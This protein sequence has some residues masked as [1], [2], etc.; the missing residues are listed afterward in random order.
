MNVTVASW[1]VDNIYHRALFGLVPLLSLHTFT[2]VLPALAAL[3]HIPLI[4]DWLTG[5]DLR[6][7]ELLLSRKVFTNSY[8]DTQ[9]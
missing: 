8:A 4:L 9:R 6:Y 7:H 5:E 1:R 3:V 2:I